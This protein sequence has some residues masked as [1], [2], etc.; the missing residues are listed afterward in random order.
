MRDNLTNTII[1]AV[2]GTSITT[3]L[4]ARLD[5]RSETVCVWTGA[6]TIQPTGSGDSLL[7]GLTFEPLANGVVVNI[8]D[9]KFSYVGPDELNITLA[10]PAAPSI[11]MAAAEVYPNEYQTRPATIWRAILIRP[12]DPLAEAI[13]MF[14]RVRTGAMDKLEISNDG[15]NHTFSLTI[16]SHAASI[17]QA[18][19]STYLDQPKFDPDDISQRWAPY[20]ASNGL[21]DKN[22]GLNYI[23]GRDYQ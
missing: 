15:T 14:R 1:D 22:T 2:S 17:S 18:S 21:P 8:G 11:A 20:I 9:N 4:C 16:E 5:F 7:D 6:H 12:A 23:D 13:W 10:V 19:N 3:A